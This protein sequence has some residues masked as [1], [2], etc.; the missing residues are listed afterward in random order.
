MYYQIMLRPK[1]LG[2][3][4]EDVQAHHDA[5]VDPITGAYICTR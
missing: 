2:F 4:V 5:Y 1:Y 3:N